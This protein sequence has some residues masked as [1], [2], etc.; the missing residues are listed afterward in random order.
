MHPG[1]EPIGF[2]KRSQVA[3]SADEGFL[4]GILGRVAVAEDP[5][6]DRIQPVIHG[7][8][9][10]VERLTIARLCSDDEFRPQRPAP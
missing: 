10:R 6:S 9:D 5:A 2:T 3:P 8:R 4:H 1:L 7:R